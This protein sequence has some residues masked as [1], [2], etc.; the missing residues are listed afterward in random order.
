MANHCGVKLG[1]SESCQLTVESKNLQ[2]HGLISFSA[3]VI[4]GGKSLN[5]S[6]CQKFLYFT[7][8]SQNIFKFMFIW[9][10]NYSHPVPVTTVNVPRSGSRGIFDWSLTYS[11]LLK[12]QIKLHNCNMNRLIEECCD[13]RWCSH[14]M[15]SSPTTTGL[16]AKLNFAQLRRQAGGQCLG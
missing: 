7:K 8:S 6:S 15:F 3:S 13:R 14:Q 5:P 9:M 4:V 2:Q 10:V 11:N 1:K 16:P 12:T